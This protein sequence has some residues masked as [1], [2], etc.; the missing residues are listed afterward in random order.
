MEEDYKSHYDGFD[1]N[2]P[3]SFIGLTLMQ[4]DYL[5]QSTQLARLVQDNFTNNL[6]R[7]DRGVKQAGFWVL[8]N[9]YMPSIL[10]ET[11]FLTYKPEGAY[12]NSSKGQNEMSL[13]IYKGVMDY[14]MILDR[15]VGQNV[16][17]DITDVES[18]KEAVTEEIKPD[19]TSAEVYANTVFKVQLAASSNK[20]EPKSFNFKGLQNISREKEGKLFKYYY[21]YSSDSNEVQ[22]LA[23]VAKAQGY[24]SSFIVAYQNG[25]RIELSQ[26]L[27]SPS[28]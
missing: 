19:E 11:G 17:K 23:E 4:E 28:N 3:E 25:K 6:K 14:K 20:I 9:T 2:A 7:T 15:N 24:P 12:L 21:G 27:K 13:S 22:K 10:V 18:I 5:D 8:H 1:P 16:Y 26:V